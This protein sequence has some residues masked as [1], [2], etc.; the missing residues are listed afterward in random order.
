MVR[1]A[2]TL[3]PTTPYPSQG[4]GFRGMS[5]VF[6]LHVTPV[7]DPEPEPPRVFASREGVEEY[8]G[9]RGFTRARNGWGDA[10]VWEAVEEGL[11]MHAEARKT[12]VRA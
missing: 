8:M 2:P 5:T 1:G 12:R 4:R 7:D 10:L 6:V 9:R 3:I 11:E